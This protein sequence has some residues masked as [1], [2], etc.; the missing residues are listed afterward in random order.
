MEEPMTDE[1]DERPAMPFADFARAYAAYRDSNWAVEFRD[2]YENARAVM[3]I[4]AKEIYREALAG[5][6]AP[7]AGEAVE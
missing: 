4:R 3:R 1:Q 5:D 7:G 6:A 2:E